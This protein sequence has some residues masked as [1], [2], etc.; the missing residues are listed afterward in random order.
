MKPKFSIITPS[1]NQADYIEKTIKSVL[2][3]NYPNLEYIVIDG[4]ST[5]GSVEII[6]RYEKNISYWV[7]EKDNGQ[8]HAIN[9]A[10][11]MVTGDIVAWINSDDWYEEG[12]FDA[13]A[14]LY[15]EHPGTVFLGNCTRHYASDGR[16]WNLK[17]KTPSTLSLLRYWRRQFCPPQPSIFF[18]GS[19][20]REVGLLDEGL[21]FAM[22]LDLWI[23]LSKK[24][25][26]YYLNKTLS[27][28]LIHDMSKSGSGNG[29]FKFRREWREVCFRHV[30]E[31]SLKTKFLF[32]SDYY[33]HRLLNDSGLK[34]SD[35]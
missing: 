6:K 33:F 20:V 35:N 16:T 25:D 13:I 29:F 14:K 22:D 7:S 23:R 24:Y 21:N 3:Q 17:P 32:Y 9:K 34:V 30:A 4:G 1:Y 28:Y 5:D 11:Q 27:H 31:A 10:L 19:A 26:F 8:S 18:P 15:S 2:N 12:A